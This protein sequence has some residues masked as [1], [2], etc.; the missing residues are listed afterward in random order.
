MN[1]GFKC[2]AYPNTRSPQRR[3]PKILPTRP[4][5]TRGTIP[6]K[7]QILIIIQHQRILPP[8]GRLFRFPL[9]TI[10]VHHFV[11]G[12]EEDNI[13]HVANIETSCPFDGFARLPINFIGGRSTDRPDGVGGEGRGVF[14]VS[15][16]YAC[17][18][19]DVHSCFYSIRVREH[20]V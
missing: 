11:F 1:T 16:Y 10:T 7:E 15:G 14:F 9:R 17:G 2:F 4:L 3:I 19:R 5:I 13:A 18:G 6:L 8:R 20:G 12:I